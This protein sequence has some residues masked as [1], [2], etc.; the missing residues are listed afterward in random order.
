VLAG[1]FTGAVVSFLVGSVILRLYP[2]K[3]TEEEVAMET[4]ASPLPAGLPA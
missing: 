2:V 4:E 3:Q 1:V